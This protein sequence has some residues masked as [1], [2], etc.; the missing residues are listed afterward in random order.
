MRSGGQDD[1]GNEESMDHL[2][3]C[4]PDELG[5]NGEELWREDRREKEWMIQFVSEKYCRILWE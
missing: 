2:V 4:F 1:Y 3:E 5:R